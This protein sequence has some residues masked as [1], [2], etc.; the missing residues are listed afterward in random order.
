M[1]YIQPQ[2]LSCLRTNWKSFDRVIKNQAIDIPSLNRFQKIKNSK[3][4]LPCP[5]SPIKNRFSYS[6]S[7]NQ[8]KQTQQYFFSKN[9][10]KKTACKFIPREESFWWKVVK[11]FKITWQFSFE[12]NEMFSVVFQ[13]KIKLFDS[14]TLDNK[15]REEKSSP[16]TKISVEF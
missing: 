7:I 4:I 2:F 13:T 15:K 11:T 14:K 3:K 12:W 5:T 1:L 6:N 9:C 10:Q 16:L 8:P